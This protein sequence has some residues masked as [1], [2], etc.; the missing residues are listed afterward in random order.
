MI[1][2]VRCRYREWEQERIQ[3]KQAKTVDDLAAAAERIEAY[4][5][6]YTLTAIL[7]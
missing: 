3:E 4:D 2:V 5:N 6:P 7:H 1:D